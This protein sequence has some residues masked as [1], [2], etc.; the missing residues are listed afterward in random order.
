M[1]QQQQ[2]QTTAQDEALPPNW[3]K[4]LD[5]QVFAHQFCH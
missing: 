2:Y 5:R 1:N 3:E 4:F